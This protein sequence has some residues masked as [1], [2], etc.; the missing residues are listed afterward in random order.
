MSILEA[1]I[2]GMVFLI[3]TRALRMQ[4]AYGAIDWSVIFLLVAVLPMGIAMEETGLAALLGEGIVRLGAPL[5]AAVVL[6]L[7]I[8]VTSVLT[9]FITNNSAAILMVPIALSVAGELG[10]D[11]KPFLMGVAF[12]ASLSF[13]TPTG[14]QTNTM[15]LGPGGY[16]FVDYVKVGTPLTV[17]LWLLA[18]V[19]IPVVWPL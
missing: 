17:I 8:L 1:A 9:A 10:A 19:L 3:A 15:V 6:S 7:V 18:S 2:L 12:A 5:G 13:A 16:R 4:Q 14:Y 11:P